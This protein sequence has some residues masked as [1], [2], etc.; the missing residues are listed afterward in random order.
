VK[1]E[2][3]RITYVG[4]GGGRDGDW[5][6]SLLVAVIRGGTLGR[7]GGDQCRRAMGVF[8]EG[9]PGRPGGRCYGRGLPSTGGF[10]AWLLFPIRISNG[11]QFSE[12]VRAAGAG[13]GIHFRP[14]WG[15]GRSPLCCPCSK[16]ARNKWA[17]AGPRGAQKVGPYGAR[18]TAPGAGT[19][20]DCQAFTPRLPGRGEKTF[21]TVEIAGSKPR[22][23][24]RPK[25][26]FRT[27]RVSAGPPGNIR[28][29]RPGTAGRQQS[30]QV[31]IGW[32]G[33]GGADMRL[34]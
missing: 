20:T 17:G 24:A 19:I 30:S 3:G 28:N 11:G 10:P 33:R 5:K 14:G 25:P 27:V 16:V 9:R 7:G 32:P 12:L 2:Y 18:G 1:F 26:Q 15:H 22:E 8:N 4:E 21:S 31:K 6:K 23:A 29:G 13:G 34:T